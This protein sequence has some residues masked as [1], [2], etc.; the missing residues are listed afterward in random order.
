MLTIFDLQIDKSFAMFDR[1]GLS[2]KMFYMTSSPFSKINCT[3]SY[4]HGRW[5]IGK[6][7]LN[8]SYDGMIGYMVRGEANSTAL[9]YVLGSTDDEPVTPG[10]VWIS[11]EMAI[12]SAKRVSDP[13]ELGPEGWISNFDTLVYAYMFICMIFFGVYSI[14]LYQSDEIKK[15]TDKIIELFQRKRLRF[16]S[17]PVRRMKNKIKVRKVIKHT[18]L[19]AFKCMTCIIRKENFPTTTIGCKILVFFLCLGLFFI[20]DGIFLNLTS[21]DM[22]A[23]HQYPVIDTLESLLNHDDFVHMDVGIPGGLWEETILEESSKVIDSDTAMSNEGKL[24]GRVK[25][26]IPV[27]VDNMDDIMETMNKGMD[28]MFKYESVLVLDQSI[29]SAC[30]SMICQIHGIEKG[31]HVHISRGDT[32]A[33]KLITFSISKSSDELLVKWLNYRQYLLLQSGLTTNWVNSVSYNWIVNP[34]STFGLINDCLNPV[35]EAQNVPD[36]IKIGYI[37]N[38]IY[39]IA[40]ISVLDIFILIFE[41]I[42]SQICQ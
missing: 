33:E 31:R 25:Y 2:E 30:K 32:F 19:I 42:I 21:T 10:P 13:D 20:I 39:M 3:I 17:S 38:V 11:T 36:A 16:V 37:T 27:Q 26:R 15:R 8:G 9:A 5:N 29:I 24:W 34:S 1:G 4:F 12:L 40:I 35:N 18:R 23:V 14:F 6:K 22:I 28:K 41:I 7:L